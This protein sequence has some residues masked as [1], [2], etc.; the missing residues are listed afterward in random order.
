M[1]NH[2]VDR[3]RKVLERK[4]GSVDDDSVLSTA[5]TGSSDQGKR[6]PAA[7]SSSLLLTF[8]DGNYVPLSVVKQT[9]SQ[10]TESLPKG[11][12]DS[13]A[14]GA[15][16]SG[17]AGLVDAGAGDGVEDSE[18]WHT[19]G[20]AALSVYGHVVNHLLAQTLPITS[21]I[22]YWDDLLDSGPMGLAVHGVQ[23]LPWWLY[24][25]GSKFIRGEHN[26]KEALNKH[27]S[28]YAHARAGART[29]S[30]TG[31]GSDTGSGHSGHS[32]RKTHLGTNVLSA[33]HFSLSS[34][35][36]KKIQ[37]T[38]ITELVYMA[39]P[40]Y[41]SL[42]RKI[43]QNRRE[44]IAA[45]DSAARRLGVVVSQCWNDE[46]DAKMDATNVAEFEAKLIERH[47][48]GCIDTIYREI[49]NEEGDI[50]S[51][52]HNA[53]VT[54][55]SYAQ[56]IITVINMLPADK[57]RYSTTIRKHGT[58]SFYIRYWPMATLALA[59]AYKVLGN[60]QAIT[61]WAKTQLWETLV[62][63]WQNRLV[64][65][66]YQIY[67]TIRYDENE[68][69]SLIS[70]KSLESDIQSLERMVID[71]VTK[72]DKSISPDILQTK[73]VQGD[74][75][76]VLVNYEKQIQTPIRSIVNGELIRS[77]LI[78]VQKA[79]VDV[80]VAVSGIDKLLQSQQLVF[81]LVAALPAIA[82]SWWAVRAVVN[83]TLEGN[84]Q[85]RVKGAHNIKG[86]IYSSLYNVKR[87]LRKAAKKADSKCDLSPLGVGLLLCETHLLRDL[88][89][90][91]LNRSR[92]REFVD[93][94]DQLELSPS[95]SAK[96]LALDRIY[97]RNYF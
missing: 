80:E 32:D 70:K 64:K 94:L 51:T 33:I 22:L 92:Y 68:Q 3:F 85:R 84:T 91:I 49:V 38:S 42:R 31:Q 40:A 89:R 48:C 90:Q 30:Q 75:T 97:W 65:P 79:K 66:L 20:W 81:G 56:R 16:G 41:V 62:A 9:L 24:S 18:A 23:V 63:F 17:A 86:E 2:R 82:V 37:P 61:D 45:R 12:A 71:L 34:I 54:P 87:I 50:N 10:F 39:N 95:V 8:E 69:L 25:Q 52:N 57:D 5:A 43:K 27:T 4:G 93:D 35:P 59:G 36:F 78:Q 21:G 88:S 72:T 77:L 76:D 26:W 6:A 55:A 1:A 74:L 67:E 58:P 15:A 11:S 14:V 83:S 60:W 96:Q 53:T 28:A 7:S 46:E 73:V 44:L 13:G 29:T 19:L 47:T